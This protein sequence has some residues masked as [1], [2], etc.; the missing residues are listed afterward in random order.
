[1]GY[2]KSSEEPVFEMTSKGD[3]PQLQPQE[4]D[5]RQKEMQQGF[6]KAP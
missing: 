2:S 5:A 6:F 3:A 1:M 4:F